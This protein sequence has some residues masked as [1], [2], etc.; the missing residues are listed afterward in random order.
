MKNTPSQTYKYLHRILHLIQNPAFIGLTILG[1]S[2]IVLGSISF[3]YFEKT[4]H[5][6][7][8]S[9]LDC[10]VFSTGIVT[11]VGYGNVVIASVGGKLTVL[12]LMLMGTIFVWSYMAFLVTALLA[13]ELIN[14]EEETVKMEKKVLEA[15]KS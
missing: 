6:P 3:Y 4:N 12:F 1:N 11:T 14:L 10:L 5:V 7:A 9:Y 15:E 8:L 2:I 13:P